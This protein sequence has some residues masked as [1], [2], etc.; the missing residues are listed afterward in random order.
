MG[1]ENK[2]EN[3][4]SAPIFLPY[5]SAGALTRGLT[6]VLSRSN[7]FNPLVAVANLGFYYEHSTQSIWDTTEL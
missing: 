6:A 1:A 7:V 3:H 4:F 5:S 2:V